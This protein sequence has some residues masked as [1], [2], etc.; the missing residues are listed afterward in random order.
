MSEYERRAEV[1]EYIAL[2]IERL[3][4]QADA[5]DAPLLAHLLEQAR[6]EAQYPEAISRR[7]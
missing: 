6:L 2:Q 5:I 4:R 1:L 7:G 3:R